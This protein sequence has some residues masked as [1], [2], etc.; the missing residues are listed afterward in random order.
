MSIDPTRP[1]QLLLR[2]ERAAWID[3]SAVWT[4][5]VTLTFPRNK[6]GISPSEQAACNTANHLVNV[7]NR[8]LLGRGNVRNGHRIGS[9]FVFGTGPY[10]DHPHIHMVLAAP[11]GLSVDAMTYEIDLAIHQ[12]QGLG[13]Q[14]VI[15]SYNDSGWI[16]YMLDHCSDGLD[17]ELVFPATP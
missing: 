13:H 14:L 10:G 5:A 17:V 8:N 11:S 2:K 4:H 3:S 7:L 12:T 16:D 9:G 15:K 6:I 1:T